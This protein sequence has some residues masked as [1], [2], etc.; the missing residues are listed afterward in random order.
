MLLFGAVNINV[1]LLE[2]N[3]NIHN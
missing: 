3:Y 1:E 2:A